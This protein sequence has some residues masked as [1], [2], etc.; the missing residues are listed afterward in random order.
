[1]ADTPH[2]KTKGW[3]YL[4]VNDLIPDRVKIGYT[5]RDPVERAYELIATGTTGTFVVIYQALVPEPFR[6]EQEVHRRLAAFNRGREWFDICPNHAKEEIIAV[7]GGVLYEETCA[8]WHRSQP[9][10]SARSQELLLEA[11]KAADEKRRLRQEAEQAERAAQ[12][13][14]RIREEK[15]AAFEQRQREIEAERQRTVDEMAV[16]ADAERRER[17]E[18]ERQRRRNEDRE[19][20]RRYRESVAAAGLAILILVMSFAAVRS[21]MLS[22]Y[23]AEQISQR[24]ATYLKLS[25]QVDALQDRVKAIT[26]RRLLNERRAALDQA[27]KEETAVSRVHRQHLRQ[28]LDKGAPWSE[29]TT[30]EALLLK[31]RSQIESIRAEQK[32]RRM[33]LAALPED[34]RAEQMTDAVLAHSRADAEERL[35][36]AI[37]E[38]DAARDALDR[39]LRHN[40]RD[41]SVR[42]R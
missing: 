20:G 36:R 7:A 19:R 35:A 16:A 21:L 6:V 38:R 24:K 17:E 15:H 14:A 12:E 22:P 30:H 9:E 34:L 26:L 28:G 41:A 13:Q 32:D 4:I 37:T 23:S 2:T 25:A 5:E 8:R 42:S 27:E 11:K 39:A 1:M 29:L 31:A 3:V 40:S 10:P 33:Q 18:S